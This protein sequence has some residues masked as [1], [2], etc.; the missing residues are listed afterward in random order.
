MKL[1]SLNIQPKIN[2]GKFFWIAAN[3][4]NPSFRSFVETI[5][6]QFA[7][8]AIIYQ[9]RNTL[10]NFQAKDHSELQQD[11]A[12][13]KFSFTKKY[14]QFRFK[15]LKSK[16]VRSLINAAALQEIG[17]NT[18]TP[19]AVIEE[20][21]KDKKIIYSYLITEYINYDYSLLDLIKQ[22]DHPDHEKIL[23]FLP[24]IAKDVRKMHDAGF[25]H[26]DLHAGNILIMNPH[27][28]P[29]FYYIDLNRACIKPKLDEKTRIT[30]LA[31]FDFTL[32][33]QQVF[34]K[35][36]APEKHQELLNLMA[37][38]RKKRQRVMH[39]KKKLKKLFK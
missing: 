12:V 4:D 10:A 35:Y 20:R 5:D 23:A 39:I 11:I 37:K 30:D 7:K 28:N 15:Y 24:G 14:D 27:S 16:A 17:I 9:D 6:Q 29:E 38:M 22:K 2:S 32:A 31:R 13:K 8:G 3:W 34:L 18:P 25:V 1:T 26:K 36:Y 19:I 33:E 21:D